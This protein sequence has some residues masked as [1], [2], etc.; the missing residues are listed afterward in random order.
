MVLNDYLPAPHF[1]GRD[2]SLNSPL[3]LCDGG[4]GNGT[5]FVRVLWHFPVSTFMEMPK[6]YSF[7]TKLKGRIFDKIEL[8]AISADL[9][10]LLTQSCV[11]D[12]SGSVNDTNRL[13][14]YLEVFLI[15]PKQMLGYD[16]NEGNRK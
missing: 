15:F 10:L 11:Q 5:G 6:L 4:S 1:I 3:G 16:C 14:C 7:I 8:N 12:I 9:G 13:V 2:I